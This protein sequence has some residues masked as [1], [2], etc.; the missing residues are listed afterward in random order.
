MYKKTLLSRRASL[1]RQTCVS[2]NL[3]GQVVKTLLIQPLVGRS[4]TGF[5]TSVANAIPSD[6]NHL[7]LIFLSPPFPRRAVICVTSLKRK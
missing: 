4:E 6:L 2:R 3:K 7:N 5:T 1:A